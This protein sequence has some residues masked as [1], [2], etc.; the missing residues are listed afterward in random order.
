MTSGERLANA[1]PVPSPAMA[2]RGRWSAD[3]RP[4]PCSDRPWTRRCIRV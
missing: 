1:D 2:G 4:A 3:R